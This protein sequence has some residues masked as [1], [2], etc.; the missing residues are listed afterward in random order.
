MQ[1]LLGL[2]PR[3]EDVAITLVHDLDVDESLARHDCLHEAEVEA[4]D[5]D[6]SEDDAQRCHDDPV[7]DVVDVEDLIT[8][9]RRGFA[10]LR[11]LQAVFVILLQE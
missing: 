9:G 11:L 4:P 8:R 1:V 7:L 2:E 10:T 6:D 3:D 5:H